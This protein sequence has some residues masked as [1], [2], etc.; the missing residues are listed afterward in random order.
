M[1]HQTTLPMVSLIYITKDYDP[2]ID[3][4]IDPGLG[5]SCLERH[6]SGSIGSPVADP[7]SRKEIMYETME[8]AVSTKINAY[9]YSMN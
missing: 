9:Q 2:N 8:F 3:S 6:G 1:A 4:A 7:R 5:Q